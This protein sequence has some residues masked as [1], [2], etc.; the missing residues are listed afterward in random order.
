M[1]GNVQDVCS[2][3]QADNFTCPQGRVNYNSAVLWGGM[4]LCRFLWLARVS[5][6]DATAIGPTRLYNI[7]KIY[8]GLL[9]FFWIGALLPIITFVL[10][11][12]YPKSRFLDAIHWPIF[13]A[14]TGNLPPAVWKTPLSRVLLY[15]N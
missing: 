15:A 10:R 7:G 5:T 11:K 14:G 6:D 9:H 13:F 12:K 1:L 3:D 8:S 2:E 4:T